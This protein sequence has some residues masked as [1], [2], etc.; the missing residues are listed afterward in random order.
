MTNEQYQKRIQFLEY[1]KKNYIAVKDKVLVF[2]FNDYDTSTIRTE[3]IQV[4]DK[5]LL[6]YNNER[7]E[8]LSGAIT[9]FYD[10]GGEIK[11][12]LTDAYLSVAL[13]VTDRYTLFNEIR[14]PLNL[15]EVVKEMKELFELLKSK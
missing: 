3:Y 11:L 8:T 6:V 15:K 13:N 7:S 2:Y 10:W 12:R 5:K 9:L 1:I 4:S 14:E